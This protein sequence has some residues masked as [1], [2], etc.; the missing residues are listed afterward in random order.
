[1]SGVVR[2]RSV[3]AA[4]SYP[5]KAATTIRGGQLVEAATGGV[6]PAGAGSVKVLGVAQKDGFGAGAITAQTV[7]E[8]GQ[9]FVTAA[10]ATAPTQVT[11]EK[12]SFKVTYASNAA[13]GDSLKAAANGQVTKWVVGTDTDRGTIVGYCNEVAGVTSGAVA[14][15]RITGN[16]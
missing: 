9:P 13:F 3:D 4:R 1:M 11:A 10:S 15:A 16:V 8:V 12:G 5:V 7:D 2:I 6:Q 14:E